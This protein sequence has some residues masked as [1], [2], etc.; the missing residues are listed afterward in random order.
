MFKQDVAR[1]LVRTCKILPVD[2][3][4]RFSK[5]IMHDLTS[6]IVCKILQDDLLRISK[7]NQD[8]LLRISKV[9]DDFALSLKALKDHL[10]KSWLILKYL[11]FYIDIFLPI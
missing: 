8:D 1:G 11:F 5:M 7:I 6:L 9:S 3:L 2:F 4:A 10:A